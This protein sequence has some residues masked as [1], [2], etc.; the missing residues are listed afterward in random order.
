MHI[1]LSELCSTRIL[2]CSGP[3]RTQLC[4]VVLALGVHLPESTAWFESQ[5]RLAAGQA[6]PE[7]EP[8]RDTAASLLE[9]LRLLSQVC[10]EFQPALKA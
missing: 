8:E 1:M 6:A 7:R 4:L 2:L 10:A 3:V 9:Q 5:L